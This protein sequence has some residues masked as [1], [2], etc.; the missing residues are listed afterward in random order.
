VTNRSGIQRTSEPAGGE[1]KRERKRERER[2]AGQERRMVIDFTALNYSAAETRALRD[3]FSCR[4]RSVDLRNSRSSMRIIM[5]H[6]ACGASRDKQ[7]G[8]GLCR[9][10]STRFGGIRYAL[11]PRSH[12]EMSRDVMS[13]YYS[14]GDSSARKKGHAARVRVNA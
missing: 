5:H 7:D 8:S 14:R 13:R 2:E 11:D 6:A 1:K 10:S 12:N 3:S 4:R 9:A